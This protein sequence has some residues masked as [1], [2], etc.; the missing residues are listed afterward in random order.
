MSNRF[1]SSWLLDS[2]RVCGAVS[3]RG[4]T[5]SVISEEKD[6]IISSSSKHKARTN[7]AAGYP[8][9]PSRSKAGQYNWYGVNARECV[10]CAKSERFKM[11]DAY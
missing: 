1:V 9:G 6:S 5:C 7:V 8:H 2:N 11:I 4:A 10:N 3:G